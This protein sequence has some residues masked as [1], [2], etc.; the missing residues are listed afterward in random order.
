MSSIVD[1]VARE[2]LD[3]RGNP[4]VEADVLI[5]SGV[6]GRAAVPSGA[7]TGTREALELRD[8]D[9]SRYAGKGV[10]KAV[11]HVNTEISEAIMGLDAQEQSFI[12]KTLIELD[13]TENKE[14]LGAN[15]L[16]AVSM[17][18]AKAAAEESGLPLYRYFGGSGSMQMPVPMMNVINGGAH[19]NN[20]LDIQEFMIVPVGATTFRDAL[21]CGAEVFQA[22]KKL[23]DAKGLS[24]TVGD[25]GGF[26]PSLP[27]NEAAIKLALDAISKA[28]YQP[29]TDVVLALDC[30]SSE[31]YKDGKY[32]LE[33][34]NQSLTPGKFADVLASWAEKYPIVSIEDGM[35]ESDWDGWRGLTER[36]GSKV[37]LVGDDLFVTNTK[38]LREGIQR[39]IANSIL[40]KVNQIGT[41]TETFAAIEMAKRAGY[42]A[43]I[44]HRSGETED[45]T[46]AD[47]AV[48]MNT[49]QIKTG[50][51]SRS[52]RVAKYNQLLRIEEDLGDVVGYPGR[53]AFYQLR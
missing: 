5:E 34:E 1:V 45:T 17:A 14:R 18:V 16:L 48:G 7:S 41:L 9:A 30:A 49:L 53:G 25:E 44:S 35:A 10:L 21:R 23:L 29:G 24:T 20:S 52:D 2:I 28:G 26:A 3:S 50:S 31:F 33:S 47:I 11:E 8:K 4:T 27:S 6:M 42:T 38:I 12:D 37:Q 19:A 39:G 51:L 46:I 43:V 36:L 13:G 32:I 40:I 15:A 22:L